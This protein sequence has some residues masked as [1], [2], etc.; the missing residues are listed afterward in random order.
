M[1]FVQCVSM[2]PHFFSALVG[3]DQIQGV[4]QRRENKNKNSLSFVFHK[5]G[6]LIA[7]IKG[8]LASLSMWCWCDSFFFFLKHFFF[9]YPSTV[10]LLVMG[11]DA[12]SHTPSGP[13]HSIRMV[14][15]LLFLKKKT[16]WAGSLGLLQWERK[17]PQEANAHSRLVGKTQLRGE[18]QGLPPVV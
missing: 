3:R 14:S 5:P 1:K 13:R 18:G 6:V 11:R 17:L 9:F 2:R 16:T 10:E 15:I 12:S 8:H 4:P 7:K